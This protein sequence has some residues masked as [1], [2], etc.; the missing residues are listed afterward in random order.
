MS[1]Q[2][3]ICNVFIAPTAAAGSVATHT[4]PE[5]GN[6]SPVASGGHLQLGGGTIPYHTAPSSHLLR[7]TYDKL[8]VSGFKREICGE[9][10][11]AAA[12]GAQLETK[13][14]SL[15]SLS[16]L[17]LEQLPS[18]VSGFS[19]TTSGLGPPGPSFIPPSHTRTMSPILPGKN[20]SSRNDI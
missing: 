10:S 16:S 14:Q 17:A 1:Y 20:N 9:H 2:E 13:V 11:R 4:A 19:P 6:S 8:L 5:W 18:S 7:S 3:D 15:C 12:Y